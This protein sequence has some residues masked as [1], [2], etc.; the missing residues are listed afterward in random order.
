MATMTVSN[1][2]FGEGNMQIA[3]LKQPLL[4][5][6]HLVTQAADM[7]LDVN[8]YIESMLK[9]FIGEETTERQTEPLALRAKGRWFKSVSAHHPFTNP[10][11]MT[12]SISKG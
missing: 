2:L 9:R 6:A 10:S 12:V 1:R 7:G 11:S 4:I 3:Q 5:D 8:R